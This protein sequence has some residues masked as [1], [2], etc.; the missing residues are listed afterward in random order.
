MKAPMLV[1]PLVWNGCQRRRGWRRRGECDWLGRGMVWGLITEG[2]FTYAWV[3]KL[4][5]R[6]WPNCNQRLHVIHF[7]HLEKNYKH[8]QHY[9]WQ[10]INLCK[11]PNISNQ[12]TDVH[13][14]CT[15]KYVTLFAYSKLTLHKFYQRRW[16]KKAYNKNRKSANWVAKLCKLN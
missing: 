8:S 15:C 12:L 10:A 7:S 5:T 9:P 1:T 13:K 14:L 2:H 6:V 16:S 4:S 3:D 11:M